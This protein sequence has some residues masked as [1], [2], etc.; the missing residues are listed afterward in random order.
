LYLSSIQA[1]GMAGGTESIDALKF[2]LYQ[3]DWR[4]PFETRRL[5]AA[6]ASALRRIGTPPALDVLRDATRQGSRGV[7]SAAREALSEE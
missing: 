1:L 6:A 7:R 2:A 3:G 5:R 4:A